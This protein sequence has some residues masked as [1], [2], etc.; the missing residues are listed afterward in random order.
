MSWWDGIPLVLW[1]ITTATTEHLIRLGQIKPLM[2]TTL[3]Q[4]Y[5][6]YGLIALERLWPSTW[7]LVAIYTLTIGFVALARVNECLES[8][9]KTNC[10]ADPDPNE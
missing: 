9:N 5:P 6:L 1:S 7:W 8:V 3:R 2:K 4:L 10:G